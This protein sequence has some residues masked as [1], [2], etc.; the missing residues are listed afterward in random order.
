MRNSQTNSLGFQ[1]CRTDKYSFQ[2]PVFLILPLVRAW[3]TSEIHNTD[4]NGMSNVRERMSQKFP[5]AINRA[6]TSIL[7]WKSP[8]ATLWCELHKVSIPNLKSFLLHPLLSITARCMI[9]T[10]G[11]LYHKLQSQFNVSKDEVTMIVW[12]MKQSNRSLYVSRLMSAGVNV[13]SHLW[14]SEQS[15]VEYCSKHSCVHYRKYTTGTVS[16]VKNSKSA[17]MRFAH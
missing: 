11:L 16:N 13:P 7:T 15:R 4:F 10:V 9:I 5:E 12:F 3:C 1:I 8:Y 2:N 17:K 6:S 14:K